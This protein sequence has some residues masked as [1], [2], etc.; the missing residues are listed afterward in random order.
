MQQIYDI[1]AIALEE[2]ELEIEIYPSEIRPNR[3]N[4][5]WRNQLVEIL[6]DSNLYHKILNEP[7]DVELEFQIYASSISDKLYDCFLNRQGVYI[8]LRMG[9]GQIIKGQY[10]IEEFTLS[11]EGI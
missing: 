11:S 2:P 3:Y 6:S 7:A 10:L 9:N 4:L 8:P 1:V 5:K